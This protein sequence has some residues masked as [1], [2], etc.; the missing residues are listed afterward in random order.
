MF[1]L[2]HPPI[3]V[4]PIANQ[5][6]ASFPEKAGYRQHEL[7]DGKT[8]LS[9]GD[10]WTFPVPV[11]K[12]AMLSEPPMLLVKN[13]GGVTSESSRARS[14]YAHQFVDEN[15]SDPECVY[16]CSIFT[17]IPD[18][19]MFISDTVN[20]IWLQFT[21]QNQYLGDDAADM[22]AYQYGKLIIMNLSIVTDIAPSMDRKADIPEMHDIQ[23]RVCDR[24]VFNTSWNITDRDTGSFLAESLTA[25]TL[26]R[27][28]SAVDIA[29]ARA[30][31]RG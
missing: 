4:V 12:K 29:L 26:E 22:I 19:W 11:R 13:T 21:S 15:G 28:R 6:T 30:G 24:Q 8:L 9:F 25:Q 10:G 31:Y 18:E 1:D 7:L 27:Y 3:L 2:K 17:D 20:A 5:H 23:Y 14:G 16:R